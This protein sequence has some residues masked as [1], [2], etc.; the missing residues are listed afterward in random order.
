MILQVVQFDY[1]VVNEM[2]IVAKK[3]TERKPHAQRR[4]AR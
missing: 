2:L 3:R 1:S 4:E